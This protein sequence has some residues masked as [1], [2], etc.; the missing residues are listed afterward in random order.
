MTA[1]MA[2]SETR[3]QNNSAHNL[4]GSEKPYF[5]NVKNSAYVGKVFSGIIYTEWKEYNCHPFNSRRG[6]LNRPKNVYTI[7]GLNLIVSSEKGVTCSVL[8]TAYC[9]YR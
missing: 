4:R 3:T 9:L 7:W 6:W 2:I 8:F 5:A 1:V